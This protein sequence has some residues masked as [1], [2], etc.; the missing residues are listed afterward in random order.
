MIIDKCV[1]VKFLLRKKEKSVQQEYSL[2]DLI[3][4]GMTRTPNLNL[5]SIEQDPRKDSDTN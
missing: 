1:T 5:S 4:N 2:T 3:P